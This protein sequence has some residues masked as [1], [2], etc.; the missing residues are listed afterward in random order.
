MHRKTILLPAAVLLVSGLSCGALAPPVGAWSETL[1]YSCSGPGFG[2]APAYTFA[3]ALDT[4]VPASVPFGTSPQVSWRTYLGAADAF[5]D[6][7]VAEGFTVLH[8]GVRLGTTVDGTR[9]EEIYQPVPVMGVPTTSFWA[10]ETAPASRVVTA[11]SLGRHT[12]AVEA[13]SVTAAF[14]D[15][16]GPRLATSATCVLDPATPAGHTVVDV[17]DVVAA[18]SRTTVTVSGDTALATVTSNGTPPA[19]SV[20]FSVSGKSVASGVSDGRATATL[21]D[22]PPGAHEVTATFVPDQPTQLTSS[23]ATTTY[24]VPAITTRTEA[25]AVY[26]ADRDVLKARARVTAPRAS[27]SGRVVFVLKRNGRTLAHVTVRM[28]SGAAVKTFRGIAE[29]GRYVVLAKFRGSST[30]QQSSDRVRLRVP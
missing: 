23:T 4:D 24:S 21:P 2:S 16:A 30:Y 6:W 26:A 25:S 15:A 14:S 17:F 22:V 5:R 1:V 19:G 8:A 20:S 13:L 3:A 10:W 28:S 27:V 9:Q 11:P 12:L 18:E 7:A 29:A